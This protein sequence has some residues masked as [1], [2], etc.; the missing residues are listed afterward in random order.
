MPHIRT[1]SLNEEQ[2]GTLSRDLPPLLAPLLST[3]VDNFTFELIGTKF[4]KD[5][6]PS[7]GDPMVEV[8]WFDRGQ[9]VQDQ[10]AL[11]ITECVKLMLPSEFIAVVF[12][13]LP[14]SSYYENGKHF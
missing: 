8:F 14:K 10:C 12:I 13:A 6:L 2:V 5:G 11:A 4:F 1:R 9:Q 7:E 3:S